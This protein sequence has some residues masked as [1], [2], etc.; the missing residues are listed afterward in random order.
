MS[1]ALK[2]LFPIFCTSDKS[3]SALL[4]SDDDGTAGLMNLSHSLPQLLI[5]DPVENL[6]TRL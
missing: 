4:F 1:N 6:E 5:Q 2:I 3:I